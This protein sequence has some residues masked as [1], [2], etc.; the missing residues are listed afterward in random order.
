MTLAEYVDKVS[1]V[2]AQHPEAA[3]LE[4]VTDK[5]G[6]MGSHSKPLAVSYTMGRFYDH[7]D[8]SGDF[9]PD[10]IIGPKPNEAICFWL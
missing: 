2:L 7:G 8:G 6:E 5:R 9:L 4:V 10:M 3:N 1:S